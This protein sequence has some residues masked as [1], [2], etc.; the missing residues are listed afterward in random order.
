[1][2]V[3]KIQSCFVQEL[4]WEALFGVLQ[5]DEILCVWGIF[6]QQGKQLLQSK[7]QEAPSQDIDTD[8]DKCL[9]QAA[10]SV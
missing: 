5:R 1:M 10:A 4:Q 8:T 7:S 2:H 3:N 6:I 9:P